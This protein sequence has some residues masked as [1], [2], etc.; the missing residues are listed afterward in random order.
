MDYILGLGALDNGHQSTGASF[1]RLVGQKGVDLAA[2]QAGLVYAQML[3]DIFWEE[4]PA[5]GMVEL[6][7][8]IETTEIFLVLTG[9]LFAVHTV[10]GGYSLDALGCG[11]NPLLLKKRRTQG[12]TCCP[13]P[14]GHH[15]CR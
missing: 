4:K 13:Q 7:P 1:A 11:L 9:Q 15:N 2:A 6:V 12:S 5:V 10:M 3:T 14:S 8:A